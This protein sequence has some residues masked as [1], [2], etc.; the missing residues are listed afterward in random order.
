MLRDKFLIA[1]VI[2]AFAIGTWKLIREREAQK[3]HIT[4]TEQ[5][6]SYASDEAVADAKKYDGITL[7]Y[8]IASIKDVDTVL[9][10]VHTSYVA[11]PSSVHADGVAAEYGAYVGETIRRNEPG[12]YWT[13]DSE[14]MGEKTYPLHWGK[15]EAFP[16]AWCAHRI[17]NGDE[18][19]IWS[20]YSILKEGVLDK[21]VEPNS[22]VKSH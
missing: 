16:M 2:V 9:G 10:R 3:P 14:K 13:R 11:N 20:K 7:N 22:T 1:V 21:N 4:D 19:S 8:G 12:T 6:I 18:D 15:N 17:I 5:F